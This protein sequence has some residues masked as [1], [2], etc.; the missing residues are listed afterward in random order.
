MT[1][2]EQYDILREPKLRGGRIKCVYL[3]CM[4]SEFSLLATILRCSGIRMLRA[5]SEDEADFLLAVT[6]GSVFLS[7]VTFLDGT[8]RDAL[9]MVAETHPAVPALVVADPVDWPFLSDAY[10][11][12]ACAILWK[13]FDFVRI[14]QMIGDMDQ[15]A[16]E[17]AIWLA[18]VSQSPN[19]Q[20]LACSHRRR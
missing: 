8:W 16:R 6:G 10:A 1:E 2:H 15:A 5:D 7:D 14:I 4:Q 13:P 20:N 11:R 18:E 19:A 17:R 3:T 9:H 12:G